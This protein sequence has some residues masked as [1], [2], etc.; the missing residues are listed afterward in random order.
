MGN[1]AMGNAAM[2]NVAMGNAAMGNAA[3]GN[4]AMGD[5]AMGNAAMGNAAMG[6]AAM[7]SDGRCRERALARCPDG[8]RRWLAACSGFALLVPVSPSQPET[9]LVAVTPWAG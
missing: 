8:Y 9:L 5:A 3:M 1:A 4:A 7:P 2:G 6:N